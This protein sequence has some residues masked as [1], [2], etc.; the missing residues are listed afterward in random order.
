MFM[1]FTVEAVV[2]D[3]IIA[4]P[5]LKVLP[6]SVEYVTTDAFIAAAVRLVVRSVEAL[7][8]DWT[9]AAFT[10]KVLP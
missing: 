5:T 2:V 7:K 8:V 1:A 3:V 6:T 4:E 10:E 9:I